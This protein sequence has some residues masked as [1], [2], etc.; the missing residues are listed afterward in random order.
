MQEVGALVLGEKKGGLGSGGSGNFPIL[1]H[2][3]KAIG[4]ELQ[5]VRY[6]EHS[7]LRG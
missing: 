1:S 7:L 4:M 2:H 6:F 5:G 3:H